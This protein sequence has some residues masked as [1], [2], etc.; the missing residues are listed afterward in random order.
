M[1]SKLASLARAQ[2]GVILSHQALANGMGADDLRALVLRAEW[3]VL[4]KGVFVEA[5]VV[6]AADARTRHRIDVTAAILSYEPG[7]GRPAGLDVPASGRPPPLLA[8]HLSAALLWRLPAQELAAVPAASPSARRRDPVTLL[9]SGA[10]DLVST[11]RGRRASR[12]GVR[13]RPATVP[14]DH[15]VWLEAIPVTSRA[16]TVVDL[17]RLGTYRQGVLAA[18]SAL[19]DGTPE[20]TLRAVADFCRHWPGGAQA[21]RVVEFADARAQSPAESLARLVLAEYDITDIDL[22]VPLRTRA[23]KLFLLDIVIGGVVV[24][25]I[26]G[27]VKYLD[28]WGRPR[29]VIWDEKLRE[30]AIRDSGYEVVRTTWEELHNRPADVIAKIRRA[31][32]RARRAG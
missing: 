7:R 25:E 10:V 30:D 8:G 22:Q 9:G 26:D 16:R 29:D 3:L 24:L 20:A 31:Q 6:E 15:V 32:A 27:K 14:E 4:R 17:A 21:V 2:G 12:H 23:G 1:N 18:D 19:H 28:P 5:A 13:M 11:R